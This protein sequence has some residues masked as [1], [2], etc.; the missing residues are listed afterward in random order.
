MKEEMPN[1]SAKENTYMAAHDLRQVIDAFAAIRPDRSSYSNNEF[2]KIAKNT[3]FMFVCYLLSIDDDPANSMRRCAKALKKW[4]SRKFPEL[5]K[6]KKTRSQLLF[7]IINAYVQ[8]KRSGRRKAERGPN[9][10]PFLSE[11]YD[12]LCKIGESHWR[13]DHVPWKRPNRDY[14]LRYCK[15]E[16]GIALS[17]DK[18][19][20][21]LKPIDFC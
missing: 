20:R 1:L 11:V 8:A 18:P 12:A 15:K 21:P 16:L 3:S 7:P 14:V 13:R 10:E 17:Q 2:L 5:R 19:G 9:G 4:P 6:G